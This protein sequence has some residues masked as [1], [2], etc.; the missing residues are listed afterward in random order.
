MR[1]SLPLFVSKLCV[2]LLMID[3]SHAQ[4]AFES[5][6]KDKV[7]LFLLVGQSNMAGRGEVSPIDRVVH[8]RLFALSKDAKWRHAVA[9]IHFDKKSAGV[10]L[11]RSF[12]LSLLEVDSS[13]AVGLVPAA[14]GGTPISVWAPNVYHTQTKSYPYD[15]A[16]TRIQLARQHGEL[17]GILWHQGESDC[18]PILSQRYAEALKALIVR[19][20]KDLNAEELP[21]IIGQLGQCVDRPWDEFTK[22]VDRAHAQVATSLSKVGFVSSR[23][24]ALEADCKHFNA[25]SCREFGVRYAAVYKNF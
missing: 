25:E 13:I 22:E 17:K 8:P 11:G 19:F 12:G 15:D 23:G 7:H 6:P 4:Q 20:R 2:F 14:C 10:G 16:I 5:Y 3:T 1:R 24:L 21:F 18:Q 9:P